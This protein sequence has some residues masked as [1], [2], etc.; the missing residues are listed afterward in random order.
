MSLTLRE[1]SGIDGFAHTQDD[2][3]IEESNDVA[4]RLMNREHDG[5]IIISGQ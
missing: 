1:L 4:S 3:L 5:A 2:E